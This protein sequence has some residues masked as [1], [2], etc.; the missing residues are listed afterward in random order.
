MTRR[1]ILILLVTLS[2]VACDQLSKS[3]A[4]Q[5]L[6]DSG[7]IRLLGD[8]IRLQYTENPGAF[9]SFGADISE[10]VRFWIF[11]L[12]IGALLGGLLA[13]LIASRTPSAIQTVGLSLI[14]GGGLGN[15]IDR[16]TNE[17]RVIDFL[18]LGMGSLR[19]GI[20]NVADVAITIGASFLV[21]EAIREKKR[22]G[23]PGSHG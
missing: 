20:F 19:T 6:A 14:L 17:G 10:E 23:Q 2:C 9:L 7:V 11:T 5:T 3:V 21:Y 12:L 8:T 22:S 1:I 4:R 13:Y 18:N 15:L 16:V